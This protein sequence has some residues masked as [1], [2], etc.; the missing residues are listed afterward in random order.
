M[1]DDQ[2][3]DSKTEEPTEKRQQDARKKGDVF[4]SQELKTW[5]MLFGATVIVVMFAPG[6][7]EGLRR[8]M[9]PLLE[10]PHA[11][12]TDFLALRGLIGRLSGEV[13]L[14]LAMPIG[15]LIVLAIAVPVAQFGFLVSF[16]KIKPNFKKLN[17]LAGLKRYL[18]MQP[19]ME[20]LKGVFKISLVGVSVVFVTWP[21]RRE[22][23]QVPGMDVPTQLAY[24]QDVLAIVLITVLCVVAAVVIIDIAYQR[25]A[26]SQKMRMTKQE[27]QDEHKQQEGD[28]HVKARI[29]RLR[30]ERARQRMMQSVPKSDV[31]IT[32]PTHFAVALKYDMDAM[33]A[34]TVVAKGVDHV[35]RRIREVAEENDVPI[36][37]NPPLARAL[38]AAVD[39]DQ[40]IPTE[41]YK[42]VA[43]VIGY[44]MRQKGKTRR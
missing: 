29:R 25:H 7:A 19:W 35:A 38:H 3:Q 21:R 12:P 1:A 39:I 10:S 11:I 28:P 20:L 32:N 18:T 15:L 37:E 6:V 24:L 27:V 41:H 17:P 16:Q 2:D 44:V 42:A 36:V 34:P 4:Q 5:V 26:H 31:V 13:A 43:E 33:G 23:E 9:L 14:L 22:L 40:E 30:A 8:T